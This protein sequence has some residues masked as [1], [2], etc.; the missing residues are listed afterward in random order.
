MS[1]DR[2]PYRRW[3]IPKGKQK[4][5]DKIQEELKYRCP[6]LDGIGC[7]NVAKAILD[8]GI[9]LVHDE[10]YGTE[11]IDQHDYYVRPEN[12]KRIT[13][14]FINDYQWRYHLIHY[15]KTVQRDVISKFLDAHGLDWE[16]WQTWLSIPASRTVILERLEKIED[17]NDI[18]SVHIP[19]VLQVK[20][21]NE[22]WFGRRKKLA[23]KLFNMIDT[24]K[25]ELNSQYTFTT[26]Q[27]C[28]VI[29]EVYNYNKGE[30]E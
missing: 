24:A 5:F 25:R 23:E 9:V 7:G 17:L 13:E 26:F 1:Y 20:S 16:T 3:A 8:A 30:K 11:F 6:W 2:M 18:K 15:P 4:C 28:E 29:K 10:V 21:K 19:Y 27:L 12:V 14:C 22:S